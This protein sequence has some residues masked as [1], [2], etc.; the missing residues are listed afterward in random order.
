MPSA[1]FIVHLYC[2][3]EAVAPLE[4]SEIPSVYTSL[5]ESLESGSS[6]EIALRA[7]C[8]YHVDRIEVPAGYDEFGVGPYDLWP[9][10]LLAI[11]VVCG[12]RF[13]PVD[14][15]ML[16]TSL[17]R[18]PLDQSVPSPDALLS[19]VIRAHAG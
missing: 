5:V 4:P 18:R 19:S 13:S 1:N 11:E 12:R 15:P 7:A 3:A 8:D 6:T 16:S 10:E 14:H 9:V 17:L 2:V